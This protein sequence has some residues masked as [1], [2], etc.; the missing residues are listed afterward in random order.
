MDLA[1]PYRV[2]QK[3]LGALSHDNISLSR[4]P[5]TDVVT[6]ETNHMFVA[7]V[8]FPSKSSV[9]PVIVLMTN[10]VCM[11]DICD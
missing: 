8:T 6:N 2:D 9:L 7:M 4:G 3:D 10:F 1:A 5:Y 11:T